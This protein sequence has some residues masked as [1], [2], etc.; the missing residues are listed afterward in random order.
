MSLSIRYVGYQ[1]NIEKISLEFASYKKEIKFY[2]K[3]GFICSFF[4]YKGHDP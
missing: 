4:D 1:T 3:M 2:V